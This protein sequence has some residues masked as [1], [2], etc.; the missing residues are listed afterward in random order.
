L[1]YNIA[2]SRIVWIFILTLPSQLWGELRWWTVAVTV[3][4]SYALFALAEVGLEIENP[5]GE[6]PNDL[7]LDRY[8]KLVALDLEEVLGYRK[9]GIGGGSGSGSGSMSGK[10]RR[11]GRGSTETLLDLAVHEVLAV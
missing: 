7:D 9:A 6:G 5:W 4:V 10:G 2:I 11:S 1:G 3:V 8:C